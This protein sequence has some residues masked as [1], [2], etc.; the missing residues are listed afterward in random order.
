MAAAALNNNI[1]NF[2]MSN[3]GWIFDGDGS[4]YCSVHKRACP[5]YPGGILRHGVSL[6]S[7]F[8]LASEDDEALPNT[9][10]KLPK[11]WWADPSFV[12]D[13]ERPRPLTVNI[14]GL[15]CV[16]WSA[17]GQQRREGGMMER[18]QAVWLGERV[19]LAKRGYED[20]YIS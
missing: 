14:A 6:P 19:Y 18:H 20:L 15:V 8:G 5:S 16:D 7:G 4:S 3:L 13:D 9:N 10:N 1:H 11:P 17:N 12:L 2:V